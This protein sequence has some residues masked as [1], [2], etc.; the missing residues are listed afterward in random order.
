MKLIVFLRFY[1]KILLI[2]IL[3]VTISKSTSNIK[4]KE[5]KVQSCNKNLQNR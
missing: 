1:Y 2:F 5:L 3:K 4:I